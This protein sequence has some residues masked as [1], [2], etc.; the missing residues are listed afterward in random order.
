MRKHTTRTTATRAVAAIASLALFAASCGGSDDDTEPIA[1]DAATT[2]PAN[3]ATSAATDPVT[4]DVESPDPTEPTSTADAD[5]NDL[6]APAGD[7][8]GITDDTI[9]IGVPIDFSGPFNAA[10]PFFQG[11]LDAYVADINENGGVQGRQIELVYEDNAADPNTT[12]DAVNKL[13]FDDEVFALIGPTGSAATSAILDLADEEQVIT[14]P[15]AYADSLFEPARQYTFVPATPYANQISRGIEWATEEFG[16]DT[17]MGLLFEDDDFGEAGKRG[18]DAATAALETTVAGQEAF[19]RGA[20]DLSAQTRSLV[21]AGATIIVCVCAFGQSGLLAQTLSRTGADDVAVLAP[22]PT[23]GPPFFPIA[24][25]AASNTYAADYIAHPG[26]QAWDQIVEIIEPR[27]DTPVNQFHLLTIVNMAI[28]IEAL[29]TADELSP[30]GVVA[31]LEA[32][33]GVTVPGYAAP[34]SFPDGRRFAS[35]EAAV[36]ESDP[37]ASDW[38]EVAPLAEASSL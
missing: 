25:E 30:E 10:A 38:I 19:P 4:T 36:F 29:N 27:L 37:S 34:I 31:A 9:K 33:D 6:S 23:V 8:R 1:S 32:F 3:D 13:I 26:S 20:D 5:G 11:G 22:N 12:V 2:E 17:S 16:A 7:V 18:F 35:T 14:L 24:G 21:D 28:L 15:V